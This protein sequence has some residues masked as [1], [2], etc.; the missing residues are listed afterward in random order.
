MT[1]RMRFLREGRKYPEF[2]RV[3]TAK[4]STP[5]VPREKKFLKEYSGKKEVDSRKESRFFYLPKKGAQMFK[6]E[7]FFSEKLTRRSHSK[8]QTKRES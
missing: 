2:Q 4:S 1:N 3:M 6:E 5:E 7:D 8:D